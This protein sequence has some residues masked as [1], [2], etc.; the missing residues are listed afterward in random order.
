MQ[1]LIRIAVLCVVAGLGLVGLKSKS[2]DPVSGVQREH[3]P[4]GLAIRAQS[5]DDLSASRIAVDYLVSHVLQETN[6]TGDVGLHR[7]SWTVLRYTLGIE[8]LRVEGVLQEALEGAQVFDP[9]VI[10][11]QIQAAELEEALERLSTIL[12]A[13]FRATPFNRVGLAF[14]K[15]GTTWR[16]LCLLTN[17]QIEITAPA[18]SPDKR[19]VFTLHGAL[20]TEASRA[21][22]MVLDPRGS[23]QTIPANI[24]N[25]EIHAS[26]PMKH[27]GNYRVEVLLEGDKLQ[28]GPP[29]ALMT[30]QNTPGATRRPTRSKLP[31]FRLLPEREAN[32]DQEQLVRSMQRWT[33][34]FRWNARLPDLKPNDRLN[35][36]AQIHADELSQRRTLSHI[37]LAG[38]D[39][40]GRLQ[41]A[42]ITTSI[43]SENLATGYSLL[44]IQKALETSP[45][46]RAELLRPDLTHV[47]I[48][49]A[50]NSG[51]LF[52]VQLMSGL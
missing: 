9:L 12:N 21:S 18:T 44:S 33:R 30:I 27:P 40:T 3:A 35:N 52:V 46:H 4:N 49:V 47:G 38:Q 51:V 8:N 1:N 19:G 14:Q 13:E 15:Q 22:I 50:Q 32:Q 43:V 24:H 45:S 20:L 16:L 29:A 42:K 25:Q 7:A 48:G 31:S 34:T 36:V 26:I 10:P 28:P 37:N 23:V 17:R 11:I 41:N 5:S 2:A 39:P 6:W